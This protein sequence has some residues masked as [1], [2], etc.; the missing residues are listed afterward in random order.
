MPRRR[1]DPEEAKALILDATIEEIS[2]AGVQGLRIKEVASR[3]GLSHP[4][5][6]HYFGTKAD[7]L[8]AAI[9]RELGR[10]GTELVGL[11][12]DAIARSQESG[13]KRFL[14]PHDLMRVVRPAFQRN[15]RLFGWLL[16][17]GRFSEVAAPQV[18][19]VAEVLHQLQLTDRPW[20]TFEHAL[21]GLTMGAA[22]LIVDALDPDLISISRR[23]E[24]GDETASDEYLE[25]VS[26]VIEHS[27]AESF[28]DSEA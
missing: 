17:E 20:T 16:L 10:T 1:R 25:W 12:Q 3:A 5:L 21:H 13:E 7:L 8:D 15:A 23:G 6:M 9:E 27:G 24:R 14:R 22:A 28:P 26:D 11:L 4:L 19:R 18:R 2:R